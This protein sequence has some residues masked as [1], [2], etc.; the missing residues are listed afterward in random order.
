[1]V[2]QPPAKSFLY[3]SEKIETLFAQLPSRTRG[4]HDADLA[5]KASAV[6]KH[7]ANQPGLV[8]TVDAPLA[9]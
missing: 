3:V 7:L 6:H 4:D 8:G 9:Q 1:M 5:D 2:A